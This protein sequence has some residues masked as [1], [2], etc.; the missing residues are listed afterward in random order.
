MPLSRK[1]YTS[2]LGN[3]MHARSL[4][5]SSWRAESSWSVSWSLY[6][7]CSHLTSFRMY[8]PAPSAHQ[9]RNEIAVLK[10]I[11]SGYPNIVTL[12][13]YFEVRILLRLYYCGEVV[14]RC[15]RRHLI[16]CTF[17]SIF[18]PEASSSTVY[19]RKATTMNRAYFW[20]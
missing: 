13:D 14:S 10:K 6:D 4:T 3:T 19:V 8:P 17:V 9:V 7:P 18:A 12:H 2:R 20:Y 11:S 15:P 1:L 5:R 16:I